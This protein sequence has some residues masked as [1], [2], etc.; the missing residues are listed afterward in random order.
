MKPF[1]SRLPRTR[2]NVLLRSGIG[3]LAVMIILTMAAGSASPQEKADFTG[4]WVLNKTKSD[5]GSAREPDD[6][7]EDIQ[8]NGSVIVIKIVTQDDGGKHEHNVR[9]TTDGAE[10]TIV[11]AGHEM[12]YKSHWEG[13]SLVTVVRVETGGGYTETR[14]VSKDGRTQ[15]IEMVDPDRGTLKVVLDRS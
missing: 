4:H 10:N 6:E 1:Q 13:E 12:K 15:T 5:F 2:W 3:S 14:S 9:Y 7:T 11:V 8:Q